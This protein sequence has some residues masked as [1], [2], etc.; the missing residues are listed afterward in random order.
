MDCCPLDWLERAQQQLIEETISIFTW[1]ILES[2]GMSLLESADHR[3]LWTRNPTRHAGSQRRRC[4]VGIEST[5][6]IRSELWRPFAQHELPD[7]YC[8]VVSRVE[9]YIIYVSAG[10][11]WNVACGTSEAL[12]CCGHTDAA[13]PLLPFRVVPAMVPGVF[14]GNLICE[15][16]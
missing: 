4:L 10:N 15:V 12:K 7:R 5:N 14:L 13:P 2:F 6:F 8:R 11:C 9:G 1:R 16:S 3:W